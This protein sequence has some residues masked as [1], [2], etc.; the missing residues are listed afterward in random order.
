MDAE[1]DEGFEEN[2]DV[3]TE[4]KEELS[5]SEHMATIAPPFHSGSEDDDEVHIIL[6]GCAALHNIPFHTHT[7]THT[8]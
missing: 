4:E 8:T 5:H 2:M 3:Y 7:H 6:C 1:I